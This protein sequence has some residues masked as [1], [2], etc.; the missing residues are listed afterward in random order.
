MANHVVSKTLLDKFAILDSETRSD[1]PPGVSFDDALAAMSPY[2]WA[3]IDDDVEVT[4]DDNDNPLQV[5]TEDL[6]RYHGSSPQVKAALKV[7][8][9]ELADEGVMPEE[10]DRRYRNAT[11]DEKGVGKQGPGDVDYEWL[12]ALDIKGRFGRVL[13][14]TKKRIMVG[15]GKTHEI[16]GSWLLEQEMGRP[17]DGWGVDGRPV[18]GLPR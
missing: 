4:R 13:D 6:D 5:T 16:H 12:Q 14:E 9:Q 1:L 7:L 11:G 2:L 3:T 15:R 10:F 18:D 8:W 17:P